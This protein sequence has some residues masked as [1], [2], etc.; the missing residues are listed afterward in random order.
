MADPGLVIGEGAE[1]GRGWVRVNL[2]PRRREGVFPPHPREPRDAFGDSF[3]SELR[4][5]IYTDW[6]QFWQDN[7]AVK[8]FVIRL[9]LYKVQCTQL[10]RVWES[11][12]MLLEKFH[13]EANDTQ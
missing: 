3:W 1:H 13:L 9:K 4:C 10:R 8:L 11:I 7:G 12:V 6:R 5:K 2:A